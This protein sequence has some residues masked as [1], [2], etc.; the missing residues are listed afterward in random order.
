MRICC[1]D[2][3][4]ICKMQWKA[5]AGRAGKGGDRQ[6]D[7]A[8]ETVAYINKI[9]DGYDVT[10]IACDP[11]M[12]DKQLGWKAAPS[13]RI[14][15]DPHRQDPEDP[16]ATLGYKANREHWGAP[17]YAQLRTAKDRLRADG[18]HVIMAPV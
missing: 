16:T 9:R 18:C 17:Y 6:Q 8:Q 3:S 14:A 5:L 7:T 13:F 15:Y 10:V 1:V 12:S 4:G 2:L 11:V